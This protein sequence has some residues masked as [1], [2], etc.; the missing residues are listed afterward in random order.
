M[1]VL[2][3]FPSP[4]APRGVYGKIAR[5]GVPGPC[6]PVR[7]WSVRSARS[8]RLPFWCSP[9]ARCVS[10]RSRSRGVRPPLHLAGVAYT[11]RAV[12]AQGAA[13]DAPG[14]PSPSA[15]LARVP[16]SACLVSVGMARS[17]RP[18]A[19]LS[20][21]RPHR[22]GSVWPGQRFARRGGS[23]GG[24]DD[25]VRGW[26]RLAPWT[27]WLEG[28]TRSRR[29]VVHRGMWQPPPAARAGEGVSERKAGGCACA[30][31]PG[32]AL[33]HAACG[34]WL[35]R[36]SALPPRALKTVLHRVVLAMGGVVS[37]LL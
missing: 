22:V 19:W 6:L 30:L 31:V 8:V 4:R 10:V 15:L 17:P 3:F 12:P 29:C 13:G 34:G 35:I 26:G 7:W 33:R 24:G 16:C 21:A 5:P 20:V 25:F 18:P 37:I 2:V 23:V 27:S 32:D 28:G 1:P 9:S 11:P 14:G 36:L